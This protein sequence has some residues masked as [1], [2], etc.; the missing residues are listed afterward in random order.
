[1][2]NKKILIT[3]ALPYVNNVPHLGNIIGAVLSADVFY[4]YCR[5]KGYDTIYICG[6]DEHGT[7]TETRA[8]QEGLSPEE[9]CQKYYKIHKEI[10]EWF[11]IDFSYFGRTSTEEQKEIT[12]DIFLKLYNNGYIESGQLDQ[13]F[14]ENCQRF[15]ADRYVIGVCPHCDY[16][17]ARGDQCESCGK[18]LNPTELKNPKCSVCEAT[19]IVRTTKHLFLD[20]EKIRPDLEKWMAKASKEGFW[21]TNSINMAKSW[22]KTGLQKKCITRDLKWGIPVPLEGYEDKVFYVWFDAP[23]GYI[24]ITKA[25][26]HDWENWWKNPDQVLLYQ[27]MGKDNIPFHTVIFPSSLIGA[28]DNYTLLHHISSTEYLNYET[29]KFS[30]SLGTGVFGDEVRETGIPADVWR[31]YLLKTRPEKNDTLFQ[32]NDFQDKINNE[33][34][35]NI[36][37]LVNRVTQFVFKYMAATIPGIE[38][39]DEEIKFLKEIQEKEKNIEENFEKAELKIALNEILALSSIANKFFQDSEPWKLVKTDTD[40][41]ARKLK[42]LSLVI[43][44]LAILLSPYIPETCQKILTCFGFESLQWNDLNDTEILNNRSMQKPDILFKRIEDKQI[45]EFRL[46]FNQ[47]QQSIEE[48]FQKHELRVAKIIAIERHPDAD[49]LYI[50]KIDLGNG[51]T[52]QIVS[53]LVPYYKEEELLNKNIIL[54]TNLKPAKLKGVISQGMLLAAND[55]NKKPEVLFADAEPGTRLLLENVAS[56]TDNNADEIT[57]DSFFADKWHVKDNIFCFEGKP[58][59]ING[60][61]IKT[62]IVTEGDVG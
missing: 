59:M 47:K 58:L 25:F 9:I 55:K 35:A 33:L 31:F 20:L 46:R 11:N 29:G 18:L 5:L 45:E 60:K 28:N 8:I 23:I 43:K 1:M 19:P 39:G 56:E 32:W 57:I 21:N 17:M 27:F 12:Q 22:L 16:E 53:G 34:I 15:L 24:S 26:T 4:R 62:D 37:N 48:K 49:K 2:M 30:K 13:L 54:V 51:E 42:A 40:N 6:T 44:D 3:S 38:L 50:E 41:A 52:R 14:C 10:Y 36:A 7:T 61:K